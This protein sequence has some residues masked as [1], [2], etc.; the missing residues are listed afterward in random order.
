MLTPRRR[1]LQ[2]TIFKWDGSHLGSLKIDQATE[3]DC[4]KIGRLLK[5]YRITIGEETVTCPVKTI[6][7]FLPAIFDE[8][9]PIFSL[10]KIG[11]HTFRHK[12]A[13]MIAYRP[14]LVEGEIYPN[15]TLDIIADT[16]AKKVEDQVRLNLAF[17][18]LFGI[19]DTF[20]KSLIV[21]YKNLESSTEIPLVISYL[22]PG[23][24]AGSGDGLA[25]ILPQTMLDRWF[26]FDG[27][28][29]L[30]KAM[31]DLICLNRESPDVSI[32][33]YRPLIEEVIIRL[34]AN[35]I[36]YL[37]LFLE[38]LGLYLPY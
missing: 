30:E 8:I 37:D 38:R 24:V 29:T 20:D 33:Y 10:P 3:V 28:E 31:A 7:S 27:R 13:L 25:P 22:E 12:S 34:D 26:P 14:Y 23:S 16:V 6:D 17:R 36:T 15:L 21:Q 32:A 5:V 4:V 1:N 19:T 2:R 11:C 18:E 35:L 9:K